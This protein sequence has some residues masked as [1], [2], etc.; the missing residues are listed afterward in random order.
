[1]QQCAKI[2]LDVFLGDIV[3]S[4]RKDIL[5]DH[6]IKAIVNVT[7]DID[8]KFPDIIKYH[9]ICVE[10]NATE[11][12]L[13]YFDE[14]SDFIDD[15]VKKGQAVMVHCTAAVSRSPSIIMAY[16]M[17]FQKISLR[18][19]HARVKSARKQ[20]C[21]NLGFW[22]QLVVYESQLFG[23]NSVQMFP[24]AIGYRPNI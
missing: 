5:T 6:C 15:H 24:S 23:E 10:D 18:E 8:C 16:L 9:R 7:S 13:R 14:A 20:I 12:I 4:Q 17:R 11:N 21:P 1:M 2:D 3:C 22:A 19:A